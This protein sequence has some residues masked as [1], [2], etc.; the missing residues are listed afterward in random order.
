MI[1]RASYIDGPQFRILS[2]LESALT[3][4][5]PRV[6]KI[7]DLWVDAVRV[8]QQDHLRRQSRRHICAMST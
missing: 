2:S 4:I 5:R 3:H 8:N 6:R 1:P 7:E